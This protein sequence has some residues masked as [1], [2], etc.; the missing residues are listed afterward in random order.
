[1]TFKTIVVKVNN[2][3]TNNKLWLHGSVLNVYGIN[4]CV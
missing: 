4:G 1:M 2:F 3:M